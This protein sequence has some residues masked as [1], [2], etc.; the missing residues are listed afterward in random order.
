M[1]V[2]AL[3]AAMDSKHLRV[4]IARIAIKLL[5]GKTLLNQVS[6]ARAT[7]TSSGPVPR[8]KCLFIAFCRGAPPTCGRASQLHK[9]DQ[10]LGL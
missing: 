10:V 5:K 4:K 3:R 2:H 1:E 7:C 8:T 6:Y 9:K